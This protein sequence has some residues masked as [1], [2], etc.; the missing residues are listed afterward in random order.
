MLKTEIKEIL[1]ASKEWGWVLEPEAKRLLRLAGVD[2]TR[3]Y[4]AHQMDEAL[5]YAKMIGY[6][7]V[8]KVVSPEAL[9]K[10]DVGGVKLNVGSEDELKSA[11]SEIMENAGKISQ[12]IVGIGVQKMADPGVEIIVGMTK[13]PQFGPALMFGLGGVFVEILKDV[14]FRIVPIE[15]RDAFEMIKEIKGFPLLEG[16]RGTDPVDMDKVKDLLMNVSQFVLNHPEIDE[17][18]LNPVF[19]YKDSVLVADARVITAN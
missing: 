15:E 8:A 6:P 12:D 19:A 5:Q 3:F 7:V 16:Y 10:S 17:L 9:H 4:W 11:Y 13:D 18:D 1:V 14:S 2:T